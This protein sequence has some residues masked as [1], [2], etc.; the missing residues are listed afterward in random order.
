[1]DPE[2]ILNAW[3][4]KARMKGQSYDDP[5]AFPKRLFSLLA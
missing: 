5:S 3:T 2:G 4:T 1:M